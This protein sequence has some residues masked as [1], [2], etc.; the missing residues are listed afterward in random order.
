MPNFNSFRAL[1]FH[2]EIEGDLRLEFEKK[3][4]STNNKSLPVLQS[5]E[6]S[7]IGMEDV[8][9]KQK[10]HHHTVRHSDRTADNMVSNLL[11][12]RSAVSFVEL[13]ADAQERVFPREFFQKSGCINT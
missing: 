13:M 11:L 10:S 7:I 4:L 3:L 9:I 5:G 8:I 1:S 12:K 6:M 2:V